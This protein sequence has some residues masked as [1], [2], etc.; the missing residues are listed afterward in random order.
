MA[1]VTGA[2]NRVLLSSQEGGNLS[3]IYK[4]SGAL[5]SLPAGQVLGLSSLEE[6]S[7]SSL[8]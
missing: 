6:R 2:E 4:E 7:R 3:N 1:N 8:N 5:G